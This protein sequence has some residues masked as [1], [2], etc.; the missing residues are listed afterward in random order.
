[1]RAP[2]S[3]A[4]QPVAKRRRPRGSSG[5]RASATIRLSREDGGVRFLRRGRRRELQSHTVKRGAGLTNLAD[6]VAAM[7]GTVRIDAP[8]D[9][10]PA[11]PATSPPSVPRRCPHG[12]THGSRG[13][14]MCGPCKP[15]RQSTSSHSRGSLLADHLIPKTSGIA[16]LLLRPPGWGSRGSALGAR[17]FHPNWVMTGHACR[18]TLKRQRSRSRRLVPEGRP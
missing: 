14:D 9:A 2:S 3:P 8:R 16:R 1:M 5:A 11:S 13:E 10:E 17:P 15:S 4:P 12:T 6:R 18:G 7:G